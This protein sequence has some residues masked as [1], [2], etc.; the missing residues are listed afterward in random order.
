[1]NSPDTA[2]VKVIPERALLVLQYGMAG[3][4]R[5]KSSS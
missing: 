4:K 5:W 3:L 2:F 1:M